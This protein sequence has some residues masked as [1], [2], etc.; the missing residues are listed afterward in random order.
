MIYIK[1]DESMNLA[2][3]VNEPIY[4]GD[5]LNR[6]ITYLIPKQIGEI[7]MFTAVSYLCYVRADGI[8]DII[9]L[10][11]LDE[12]YNDS[13]LQYAIPITCKMTRIPGEVC[14]WMQLY[15]GKPSNPTTAKSSE[16]MLYIQDSK[17]MD[18]YLSDHQITAIYQLQKGIDDNSEKI[19]IGLSGKADNISYD[20][21]TRKLQL[22]AN[23][24]VLGD[25]VVVP[26][27]N[28]AEEIGNE[29][30]DSWSSMTEPDDGG[31]DDS[32]EPM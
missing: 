29:V 22:T 1:L 26:S 12:P 7:D 25:A 9:T 4:R 32:W 3:T 14:T 16:C 15:S 24:E 28:Y 6:K 8:P 23:G 19:D 5:N 18:D 13:Y 27:D 30:E 11:R 2:V 17:N 10:E 31:S 21:E 20:E